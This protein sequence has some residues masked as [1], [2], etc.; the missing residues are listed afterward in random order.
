[1]M[2][3][4]EIMTEARVRMR[5]RIKGGWM[6]KMCFCQYTVNPGHKNNCFLCQ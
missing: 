1:M 4:V 6:V 5:A 2:D 3:V